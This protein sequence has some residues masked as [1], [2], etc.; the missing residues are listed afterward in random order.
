MDEVSF[1][2][3]RYVAVKHEIGNLPLIVVKAKNGYVACS[4]IDK[5]TAEKVGDVAAFVSGVKDIG[6]EMRGLFFANSSSS[7]QILS[8]GMSIQQLKN[9]FPEVRRF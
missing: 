6:C 3:K 4:Y 9:G 8:M 7:L 2:G 5:E 1:E